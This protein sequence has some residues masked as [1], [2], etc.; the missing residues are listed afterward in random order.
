MKKRVLSIVLALAMIVSA[1]LAMSLTAHAAT[2]VIPATQPKG[3]ESESDLYRITTPQEPAWVAQNVSSSSGKY[4]RLENNIDLSSVCGYE[5]GTLRL[6]GN[7]TRA[8]AANML[9]RYF[10][11]REK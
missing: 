4:Y 7:T 2:A 1:V 8:E 11:K 6:K 3:G 10:E 9:M 5:D